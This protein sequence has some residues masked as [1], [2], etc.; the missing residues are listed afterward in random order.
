MEPRRR[1]G[2][3]VPVGPFSEAVAAARSDPVSA[4]C[5]RL[6]AALRARCPKAGAVSEEVLQPI[7]AIEAAE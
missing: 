1:R 6:L 3:G 2:G 7:L 4:E 5:R